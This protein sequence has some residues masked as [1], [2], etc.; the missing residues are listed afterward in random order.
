M[1]RKENGGEERGG[2]GK[3]RQERVKRAAPFQTSCRRLWLHTNLA[4]S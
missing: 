3:G 4:G 1:G 2:N